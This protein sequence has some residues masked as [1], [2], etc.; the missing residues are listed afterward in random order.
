MADRL[1][2]THGFRYVAFFGRGSRNPSW[3]TNMLGVSGSLHPG[4]IK[5]LADTGIGAIVDLREEDR[6]DPE[7]LAQHGIRFL[8]FPVPDTWSPD[9]AQLVR[10][11]EWVLSQLAAGRK[12]LIHC[13]N[14]VGR[15]VVLA[16]C[17]LIQQ[18]QDLAGALHQVKA[19]RRGVALSQHQ[20]NGLEQFARLAKPSSPTALDLRFHSQS[21]RFVL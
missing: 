11:T 3:I 21:K 10:G 13:K 6:D 16:C 18:G 14:G 5:K 17:V 2:L 1:G 9:Q 4:H 7:L 15:S 8:H 12:T 20:M 19:C